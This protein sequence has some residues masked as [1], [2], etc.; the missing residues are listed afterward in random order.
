MT[1]AKLELRDLT[2]RL[3]ATIRKHG[4]RSEAVR[5]FILKYSDVP[6]FE[7][8]ALAL[9]VLVEEDQKAL[10]AREGNDTKDP[11]KERRGTSG[12]VVAGTRVTA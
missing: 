8:I 2:R 1:K 10:E 12:Q 4:A 3:L 11:P 5:S 7:S 6:E 9:V